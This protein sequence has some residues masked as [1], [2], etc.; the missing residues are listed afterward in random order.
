[1]FQRAIKHNHL[2]LKTFLTNLEQLVV[3]TDNSL[4]IKENHV[5]N[6]NMSISENQV[7]LPKDSMMAKGGWVLPYFVNKQHVTRYK[8]RV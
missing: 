2:I 1:M 7:F 6:Y 5:D 8:I 3:A 4:K